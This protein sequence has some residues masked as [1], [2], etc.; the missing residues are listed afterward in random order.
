MSISSTMTA[1]ANYK[2]HINKQSLCHRILKEALLISRK[3]VLELSIIRKS[4]SSKTILF[5]HPLRQYRRSNGTSLNYII[6]IGCRI[7][8]ALRCLTLFVPKIRKGPLMSKGSIGLNL[9]DP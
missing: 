1:K 7:F 3:E 2:E 6:N 4:N 5:L 8:P 9:S